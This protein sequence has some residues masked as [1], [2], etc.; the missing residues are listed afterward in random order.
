M[1]LYD[2]SKQKYRKTSKIFGFPVL[3]QIF[4]HSGNKRYQYF[5]HGLIKTCKVKDSCKHHIEKEIKI[6]NKFVIKRIED[7]SNCCWYLGDKLIKKVSV[8]E[9]FR[10]K[11]IK[12]FDK[13]YD[14]IYIL[15]ANSGE[16]YLFLTYIAKVLFKKNCSKSPLLVATKQYHTELIKMICP[17]IPYVYIKNLDINIK[18]EVFKINN[19]RFFMVF[20]QEYFADVE[21][22]I[23][24]NKIG[25]VHYFNE[26]LKFFNIKKEELMMNEIIVP[27]ESEKSMLEKVKNIKLDLDNFVFIA[28]EA[29]SCELLDN[30]FWIE[31]I[32]NYR[33]QG[34]DVFVNFADGGVDLT[35]ADF[36]S[37]FL[38]Y[39]EAFA[40][41]RRAKKIISLRSGFTEFLMQTNVPLIVLY[42]NF[43]NRKFFKFINVENI[44]A[45]F[46]INQIPYKNKNNIL[47]YCISQKFQCKQLLKT[48][49][50]EGVL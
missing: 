3:V 15:T 2:Y 40:L 23:K 4:N 39:S 31:I 7:G 36:K 25:Q 24:T 28:P 38:T 11:Y 12:Y 1:K 46:G 20:P 43:K 27:S 18:K 14:D 34:V 22:N 48:L 44:M 29:R 30:K 10:K 17:D 45:G 16:I 21:I 13:K 49:Q 41:A 8:L 42:S 5:L 47:E 9:F 6:C 32:N 37:C 50:T 19:F 35:G 26:M 33:K